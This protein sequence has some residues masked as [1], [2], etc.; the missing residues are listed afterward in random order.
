MIK[1][2]DN[3]LDIPVDDAVV[4]QALHAGQDEPGH[5]M[6]WINLALLSMGEERSNTPSTATAFRSDEWPRWLRCSKE[7][8][9]YSEPKCEVVFCRRLEPFGRF[10]LRKTKYG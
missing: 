9:V 8:A 1:W 10:D 3:I 4:V 7:V 6:K 5:N 2:M